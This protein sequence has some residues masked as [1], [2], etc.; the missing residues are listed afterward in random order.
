MVFTFY[1]GK[2][3]NVLICPGHP[4]LYRLWDEDAGSL[5]TLCQFVSLRERQS[6]CFSL[7]SS[8]PILYPTLLHNP[9]S[10]SLSLSNPPNIF[11]LAFYYLY[12]F[13]SLFP[14][15]CNFFH[16]H[17]CPKVKCSLHKFIRPDAKK[18]LGPLL[19]LMSN[20]CSCL[21]SAD[22]CQT[23]QSQTLCSAG[24]CLWSLLTNSNGL[25]L[26]GGDLG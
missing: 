10:P 5:W 18:K 9:S 13:L 26:S 8:S 11:L 2:L 6:Y 16:M 1:A 12:L 23:L 7:L 4:L 20:A 14:S 17:L 22:G 21:T 15:L 19:L 25:F 3:W 24:V